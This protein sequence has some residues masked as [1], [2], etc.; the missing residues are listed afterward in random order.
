MTLQLKNILLYLQKLFVDRVSGRY[1]FVL[2]KVTDRAVFCQD[3]FSGICRDL[4]HDD[5]EQCRFSGTVDADNGCFFFFF[6]MK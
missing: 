4:L 5:L 2:G 3:H 6:Y 1:R